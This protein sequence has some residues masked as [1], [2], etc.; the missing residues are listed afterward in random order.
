MTMQTMLNAQIIRLI[1]D[2]YTT[3][4]ADATF[5]MLNN[6]CGIFQSDTLWRIGTTAMPRHRPRPAV[7]LFR[8]IPTPCSVIG[9]LRVPEIGCLVHGYKC[10]A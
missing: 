9:V 10:F 7:A 4:R 3:G 2:F 1:L 6:A 5:S 8:R